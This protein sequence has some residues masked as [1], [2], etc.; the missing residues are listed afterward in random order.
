MHLYTNLIKPSKSVAVFNPGKMTR[1]VLRGDVAAEP[2]LRGSSHSRR[3][4]GW[5]E[6]SQTPSE[7][8][9]GAEE[10]VGGRNR[11][12]QYVNTWP[13]IRYPAGTEIWPGEQMEGEEMFGLDVQQ[14]E[15]L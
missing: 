4:Y 7:G 3:P 15:T 10:P 14:L 6:V 13:V 11:S 12:R 1:C 8:E 9:T 2:L 5:K